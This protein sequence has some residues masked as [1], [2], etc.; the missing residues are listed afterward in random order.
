MN[1]M[2]FF[3]FENDEDDYDENDD[4]KEESRESRRGSKSSRK[5][6]AR[7]SS[8]TPTPGGK[9]IL[10]NGVASDNDKRR[11]REAFNNGAMILIDLHELNQREFDE[12]G[13]DFITFMGGVAFARNGELRFIEPA[14]YLVTP[15]AEMFEIWPE[16]ES[17]E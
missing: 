12:D 2:K 3:G 8:G 14:Q 1:L 17:Q 7:N 6:N 16:G 15:K 9:L 11:L 13:K 5:D 4:Y 10:F